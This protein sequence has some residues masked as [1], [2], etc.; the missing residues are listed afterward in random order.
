MYSSDSIAVVHFHVFLQT[1]PMSCSKCFSNASLQLLLFCFFKFRRSQLPNASDCKFFRFFKSLQILVN[2]F[3]FREAVDNRRQECWSASHFALLRT[4]LE[5]LNSS[6][7]SSLW[8][9]FRGQINKITAC[10]STCNTRS[11]FGS[12]RI[13]QDIDCFH[14]ATKNSR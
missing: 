13:S 10:W 7:L 4:I 5:L 6:F 8:L 12:F 2:V 1:R 11:I 9:N 3:A 14:W